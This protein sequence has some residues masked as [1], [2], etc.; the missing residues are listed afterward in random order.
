MLRHPG[1]LLRG[2]HRVQGRLL[3]ETVVS[4]IREL[5]Q[6]GLALCSGIPAEHGLDAPHGLEL[7]AE[8]LHVSRIPA[9]LLR[10]WMERGLLV[11]LALRRGRRLAGG[12]QE[13]KGNRCAHAPAR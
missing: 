1:L 10:S 11:Q 5:L 3:E 2:G 12:E 7:L 8:R 13:G 9:E 6:R 4:D